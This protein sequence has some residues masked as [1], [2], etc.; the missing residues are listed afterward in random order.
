[1]FRIRSEITPFQIGI[2]GQKV[3]RFIDRRRFLNEARNCNQTEEENE[4]PT[5]D[6]GN[7]P[8]ILTSLDEA[9]LTDASSGVACEL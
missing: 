7:K 8:I 4:R 9:G 3:N 1:M 6:Y 5:G 2:T